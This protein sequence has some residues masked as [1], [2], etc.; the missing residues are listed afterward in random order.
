MEIP[1]LGPT[2]CAH[3]GI[4]PLIPESTLPS[5]AAAVAL[6]ADE[7]E[8][9]LRLTADRQL[10]VSHD[11]DLARLSEFEGRISEMT[12][13]QIKNVNIGFEQGWHVPFCTPREIFSHFA[14]MMV[15]MNIHLKEVGE[16]GFLVQEIAELAHK[17]GIED[18]IYLSGEPAELYWMQRLAPSI[19]RN[20][21]QQRDAP[22]SIL[23]QALQFECFSAQLKCGLYDAEL[24]SALHDNGIRINLFYCD[25]PSEID[26]YF[27]EGI[28]VILTNRMDL[29]AEY[30]I[31]KGYE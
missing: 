6:G 8:F 16:N 25:E 26:A 30:R 19:R 21:I 18:R 14:C 12:R 11:D 29:A 2:F 24:I 15:N 23:S 27:R 17:F 5:F 20:A 22:Q 7:I 28:D 10:I 9:D 13:K 31:G 1:V 4:P 3:R